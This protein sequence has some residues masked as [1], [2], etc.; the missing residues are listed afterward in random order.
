MYPK[1]Q[2]IERGGEILKEKHR[3]TDKDRHTES[4]KGM[5]E[6]NGERGKGGGGGGREREK[7]LNDQHITSTENRKILQTES[8]LSKKWTILRYA[9]IS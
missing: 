7:R 5:R 9:I 2:E 1:P 4:K 8:T 3:K 6:R